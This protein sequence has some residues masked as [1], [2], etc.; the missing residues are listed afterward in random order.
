MENNARVINF[1]NSA[2]TF[3]KPPTVA[4]AVGRALTVYGGNPGRGGHALSLAAAQAVYKV[5]SAAAE[6]FAAQPENTVFTANCTYALNMALKGVMKQGGHIIISDYEHNAVFRPVYAL[7]AAKQI[8][9]SVVRTFDDDEQTLDEIR[10]HI[11][12][13]TKCVCFTAASNVTGRIFPIKKISQL[14]KSYGICFIVDASQAAG[15][16]DITL[17][18][19]IDFICTAGHKALYGPVGTGLLISNGSYT[20]STIIE[21]G[22]GATSA[23][24]EQTPYLPERLESGTLNTVGIL[25]L[26]AG[27]DFVRKKTPERILRHETELCRRFENGISEIDGITLYPS[28]KKVPIVSFNIA[29]FPSQT[30]SAALSD[31]GFALRGGLH[32]AA[33]A[34]R[35]LGTTEQG[36]VRFSPGAFNNKEQVDRLITAVHRTA[37]EL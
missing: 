26:G 15:L 24:P 32:C 5:R 9:F 33:L 25:G 27:I 36:T 19:G 7:A 10:R 6:F 23:E 21:G 16:I 20:L 29:N 18:D 31:K 37:K 1:D 12:N 3:P 35:S 28:P 13:D 30:V 4:K 11:R 2:T 34:H 22:T 17:D 14:C 8:T